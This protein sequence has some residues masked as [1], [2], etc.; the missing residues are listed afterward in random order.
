MADEVARR[1]VHATGSAV[2]LSYLLAPDLVTWRVVQTFLA[3]CLVT[4]VFLEFVRLSIGLDWAIYDRLTREY[5]QDNPAGYALYIV[6]MAVVAGAVAVG[7][8]TTV[9]VPAMFMLAIGDPI[10]GLLGSAEASNVK[11]AWV[12]LVMFGVCT[13]L[14]S[15]FVSPAAAVLGGVAATFADGVKPTIAGY[16]VDDNFAIPVLAAAAMW[17]GLVLVPF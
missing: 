3:V 17:A 11:Q 7:L 9:A 12:L 13:L 1:L 2:P 16:V 5:E 6:G 4:V 15:P 8:P 10:S 14:A